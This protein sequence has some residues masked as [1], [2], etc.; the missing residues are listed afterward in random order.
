MR[1]LMM[2]LTLAIS[3]LAVTGAVNAAS[4]PECNICP[5]VR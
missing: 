5:F 4:P 3:Y 1:K 2:V